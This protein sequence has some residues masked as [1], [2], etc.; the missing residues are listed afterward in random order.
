MP[1]GLLNAS[2]SYFVL[3]SKL[4]PTVGIA[5]IY[6]VSSVVTID[7]LGSKTRHSNFFILIKDSEKIFPAK[8]CFLMSEKE[9]K[10]ERRK[11]I[12]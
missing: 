8:K 9:I 11:K 3:S 10:T 1:G 12:F 7:S 2:S 4:R 5:L 6:F